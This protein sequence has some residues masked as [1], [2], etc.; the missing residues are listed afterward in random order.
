MEEETVIDDN[1]VPLPEPS[2]ETAEEV[3]RRLREVARSGK[4]Q[5]E[6]KDLLA[7]K[8]DSAPVQSA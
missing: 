7:V 4:Y 8:A 5:N 2:S 3:A 1:V 6:Y